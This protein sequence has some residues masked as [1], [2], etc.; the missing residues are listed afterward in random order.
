MTTPT[1]AATLTGRARWSS[2]RVGVGAIV[3]NGAGQ[4]FLARRGPLARNE[5]GL[6]ACPGGAVEVGEQLAAA[7]RREYREEFGMIISPLAQLGAFDHFVVDGQQ[8]WVSVAFVARHES[9]E[10]CIREPGKS[11][12][13]G[14]F[15]LDALPEPLSPLTRAHL[16]AYRRL[17]AGD[18]AGDGGMLASDG[19]HQ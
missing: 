3:R 8:Q 7:I 12:D 1:V 11:S 6:W 18:G 15:M 10:P 13:C 5:Q 14:W 9:G 19:M 2:V 4:V 17:V 16:M